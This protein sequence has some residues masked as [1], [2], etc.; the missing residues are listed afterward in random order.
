MMQ[1]AV[2]VANMLKMTGH[3]HLP[4][5]PASAV[6]DSNGL[7]VEQLFSLVEIAEIERCA[8]TMVM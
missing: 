7:I 5:L 6:L 1:V 8:L 4:L 2:Y 3:G